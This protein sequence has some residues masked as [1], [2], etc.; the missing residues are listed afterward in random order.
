[1]ALLKERDLELRDAILRVLGTKTVQELTDVTL[2]DSLKHEL[3]AVLTKE[4]PPKT[5]HQVYLPQFVIQ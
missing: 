1:M 4:L 3:T 5:V 2:R